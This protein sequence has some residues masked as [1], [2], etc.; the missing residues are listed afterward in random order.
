MQS[1]WRLD[2][3]LAILFA[4]PDTTGA[5]NATFAHTA[6]PCLA[7]LLVIIFLNHHPT[8]RRTS[9]YDSPL[10]AWAFLIDTNAAWADLHT[11]L[12]LSRCT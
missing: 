4:D 11:D 10:H 6:G 1:L 7:Y 9:L 3:L 12:G 2:R 8:T 5:P